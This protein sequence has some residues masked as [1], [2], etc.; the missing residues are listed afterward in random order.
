MDERQVASYKCTFRLQSY[1]CFSTSSLRSNI[2]AELDVTSERVNVLSLLYCSS[3]AM[4][5][6]P[7]LSPTASGVT[8]NAMRITTM[9]VGRVCVGYRAIPPTP[10]GTDYVAVASIC[11]SVFI[12]VWAALVVVLVV[13]EL[14]RPTS[15]L[16][17]NQRNAI[18]HMQRKTHSKTRD[19]LIKE[20]IQRRSEVDAACPVVV[21][22]VETG[23][24]DVCAVCL[25]MI[26]C[27][28]LQRTLL[29]GHGFHASC[30]DRWV[31]QTC[32]ARYG[33]SP[34]CPMCKA[35]IARP[36]PRD[37]NELVHL[38]TSTS[39]NDRELV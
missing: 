10:T 12:I 11:F 20:I 7:A 3:L 16:A 18:V 23:K 13:G 4:S 37:A 15:S 29:C 19:S 28:S 38:D 35:P 9:C 25:D 1:V 17:F 27:G 2:I 5:D 14:L 36:P 8:S 33:I 30:I 24:D 39:P 26:K 22:V 32:D 34:H 21:Q 31:L 6:V